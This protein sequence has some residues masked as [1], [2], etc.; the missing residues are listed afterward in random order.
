MALDRSKFKMM[1][2]EM[3]VARTW[4]EKDHPLE[5]GDSIEG[6]YVEKYENIGTYKSNVY[7]LDVN[8]ERIG[9]WGSTVIDE[10]MKDVALGSIVG[11]E[12]A[13]MRQGKGG[14]YKDFRLGVIDDTLGEPD[15]GT[16]LDLDENPKD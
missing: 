6:K 2:S 15:H 5:V 7:V 8:G 14:E 10:N 16:I 13:G 11:F 3:D 12:F 9:V 1:G 4:P